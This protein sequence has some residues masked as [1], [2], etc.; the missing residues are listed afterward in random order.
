MPH[1]NTESE[2][3]KKKKIER[4]TKKIYKLQ[5]KLEKYTQER[6]PH[7]GSSKIDSK[8][9]KIASQNIHNIPPGKYQIKTCCD[10][11][12]GVIEKSLNN[13]PNSPYFDGMENN[14]IK[15]KIGPEATDGE[16]GGYAQHAC[17]I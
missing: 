15:L 3:R 17:R 4:Y 1:C 12:R 9:I 11:C 7:T 16:K 8:E 5:K 14:C 10:N 2:S 13:E 6:C